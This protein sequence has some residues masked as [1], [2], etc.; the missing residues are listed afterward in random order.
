[1]TYRFHPEAETEL[2]GAI[3]YYESRRHGLGQEFGAAFHEAL[4]KVLKHP[5]AWGVLEEPYRICKLRRFPYGILYEPRAA[6]VVIVAV[7]HLH[8]KPGYWKGR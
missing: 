7:M 8:R 5:L 6:E 1:M 4:D 3:D 2:Y